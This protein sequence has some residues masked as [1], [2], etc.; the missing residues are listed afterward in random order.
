MDV[1]CFWVEHS[2]NNYLLKDYKTISLLLNRSFNIK[3]NSCLIQYYPKEEVVGNW[4][5]KSS[6]WYKL[7]LS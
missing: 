1:K 5:G 4:Y 7:N 2:K 3:L 6:G